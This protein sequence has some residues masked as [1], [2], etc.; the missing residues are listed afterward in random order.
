MMMT[1]MMMMMMM[2]W[3]WRTRL[4]EFGQKTTLVGW[5]QQV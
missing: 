4:H 3:K 1:T 5:K 2:T